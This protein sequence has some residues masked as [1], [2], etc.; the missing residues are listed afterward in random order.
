M[1]KVIF[2]ICSYV[3][4]PLLGFGQVNIQVGL[5]HPTQKGEF[6]YS[7]EKNG[8][9]LLVYKTKKAIILQKFDSKLNLASQDMHE[10]FVGPFEVQLLCELNGR[11][12]LFYSYCFDEF[13]KDLVLAYR[14]VDFYKGKFKGEEHQLFKGNYVRAELLSEG[15]LRIGG[16]LYDQNLTPIPL[17]KSASIDNSKGI[18]KS[19]HFSKTGNFYE[20]YRFYREGVS[21]SDDNGELI[22]LQ[23]QNL[24][25]GKI[26]KTRLLLDKKDAH[27]KVREA[28]DGSVF[29]GGFYYD[30]PKH[31]LTSVVSG[32]FGI[33]VN[34]NGV[35][36]HK[37]FFPIPLE[38]LNQNE[39]K[40]AKKDNETLPG[41]KFLDLEHI[42]IDEEGAMTIVGEH[43]YNTTIVMSSGA[44]GSI[45]HQDEIIIARIDSSGNLSWIKKIPKMQDGYGLQAGGFKILNGKDSKYILY[46]DNEK[47][48]ELA[49]DQVPERHYIDEN[50]GALFA[51]KINNRSGESKKFQVFHYKDVGGLKVERFNISRVLMSEVGTFY[52]KAYESGKVDHLIK[53]DLE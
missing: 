12:L 25:S 35:V 51:Y 31:E 7:F 48:L 22:E 33:K 39:K 4:L 49:S 15:I 53:V 9:L 14:E 20:V 6:Q 44:R 41:I 3:L 47:N 36:L 52:M 45:I 18:Y 24:R 38:I 1:K 46:F 43:Q 19:S 30:S 5:E 8:E 28:E 2:L 16:D 42:S 10:G 32:V 26:T 37:S 29:I 40:N 23:K 11:S 21:E 13:K 27:I 17:Q 34:E 50:K